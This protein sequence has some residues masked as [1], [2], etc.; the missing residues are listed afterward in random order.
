[1][2]ETLKPYLEK[3]TIRWVGLSEC[4]AETLRRAK[5]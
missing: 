2:M 4:S 5:W 3:G 1:V